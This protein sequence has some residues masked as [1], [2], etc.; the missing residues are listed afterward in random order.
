MGKDHGFMLTERMQFSAVG[1]PQY[2]VWHLYEQIVD[3][4]RHVEEMEQE[5][6]NREAEERERAERMKKIKEEFTEV[7]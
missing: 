3:D 4:I 1:L 2:T 7:G 5:R 6:L